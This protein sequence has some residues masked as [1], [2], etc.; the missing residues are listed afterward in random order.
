[1]FFISQIGPNDCAFTCLKILLAN[2][3]HDKNYLFMPCKDEPYSFADLKS[4]AKEHHMDIVGVKVSD[5]NELLNGKD[6][7]FIATVEKK[8]GVRH[9][10]LVLS[11]TRK[12]VK[13]FDPETGR[14]KLPF[15]VFVEIWDKKALI[16]NKEVERH[17]VKYKDK[18]FD[19][20]DKKDKIILPVWQLLSGISLMAGLYFINSNSYFFIP[21]IFF[22][23]FIIFEIFFRKSMI[24]ALKRMDENYFAYELIVDKSK[25]PEVYKNLEKY[26]YTALSITPNLIYTMLISIFVTAL[27]VMNGIINVIYISLALVIAI[28]HALVFQPYYRSKSNDIAEQEKEISG[29]DNFTQFRLAIDK[30]HDSAYH[31]ALGNNLFNYLEIAVLLMTSI[32]IMTVSGI[33]NVIYVLF[34]TCIS[35]Y[36][37]DNFEKM[38]EYDRQSEEFD[39]LLAKL[40]HYINLNENNSIE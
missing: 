37:K 28:L 5:A 36:L 10:V 22:A 11:A 33:V 40:L 4:I 23:L 13:V 15:E 30:A 1:M 29:A 17:K 16:L 24:T 32:T 8:K 26:R 27:L 2:Y 12:H 39:G 19:F 20:I 21:I 3:H 6:F 18:V 25:Y 7:P 38:F 9:S 31:V 34:Y 14:R 35:I